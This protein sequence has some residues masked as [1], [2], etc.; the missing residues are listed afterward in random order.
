MTTIDPAVVAEWRELLA[1]ERCLCSSAHTNWRA[2]D[3]LLAALESA[4]SDRDELRARLTERER[5]H[6]DRLAEQAT[7]GDTGICRTCT[8]LITFTTVEEPGYLPRT[9]W[10]DG[11][12]RDAL[13]CFKA[14]GYRHVPLVGRERGIWDAATKAAEG[15]FTRVRFVLDGEHPMPYCAADSRILVDLI[16]RARAAIEPAPAPSTEERAE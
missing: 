3:D 9:G 1:D 2:I 15:A 8:E 4:Q 11:A 6:A 13:V 10:S 7:E 12:H 5:E 16:Q 14:I